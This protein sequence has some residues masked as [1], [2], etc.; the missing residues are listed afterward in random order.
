MSEAPA[1][2]KALIEE[3]SY[4]DK[5]KNALSYFNDNFLQLIGSKAPRYENGDSGKSSLTPLW[6]LAEE[7]FDN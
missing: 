5:V 3:I 6:P 2:L 7:I 1:I 4:Y